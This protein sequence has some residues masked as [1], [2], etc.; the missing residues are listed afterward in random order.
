MTGVE[1]TGINNTIKALQPFPKRKGNIHPHIYK[2]T[3]DNK[4]LNHSGI[5]KY[6]MMDIYFFLR[7]KA[8]RL[9]LFGMELAEYC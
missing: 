5:K 7:F 6:K 9:S 3:Q 1:A 8:R 4:V 2:H